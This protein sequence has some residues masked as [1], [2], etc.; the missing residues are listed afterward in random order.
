[1]PC[2][3]RKCPLSRSC[4][5]VVANTQ[6]GLAKLLC[7]SIH[8]EHSVAPIFSRGMDICRASAL[9]AVSSWLAREE[10]IA[11]VSWP[12]CRGNDSSYLIDPAVN[13]GY[14]SMLTSKIPLYLHLPDIAKLF[15]AERK[16]CGSPCAQ[17]HCVHVYPIH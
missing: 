2:T 15:R 17:D 7:I 8:K 4:L 13:Q 11:I 16:S 3:Q 1:M 5:T 9:L 14:M 12:C 6:P 10:Q